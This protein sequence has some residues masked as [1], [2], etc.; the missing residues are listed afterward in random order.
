MGA[1]AFPDAPLLFNWAEGGRTP[2]YTQDSE[3][4]KAALAAAD[5]AAASTR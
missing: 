3:V 4:A 1:L 2:H 5:S